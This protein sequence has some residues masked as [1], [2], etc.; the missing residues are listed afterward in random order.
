MIIVDFDSLF[1]KIQ[2]HSVNNLHVYF[3]KF[4]TNDINRIGVNTTCKQKH[5][6]SLHLQRRYTIHIYSF[7]QMRKFKSCQEN[8]SGIPFSDY[9]TIHFFS[10]PSSLFVCFCY[11]FWLNVNIELRRSNDVSSASATP[12]H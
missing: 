1:A 12:P 7:T 9:N 3:I 2:I 6:S 4:R 11:M 8:I 5:L 10:T